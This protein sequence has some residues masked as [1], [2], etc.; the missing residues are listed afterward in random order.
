MPETPAWPASGVGEPATTGM[1]VKVEFQ[2]VGRRL[3]VPDGSSVYQAARQAGVELTS[4]CGGKGKCGLCTVQVRHGD[5]GPLT[6]E[7]EFL[8]TEAD[9]ATGH[10]LACRTRLHT[11]VLV[12][13]PRG[14]QVSGQRLQVDAQLLEIDPRP[15][16]ASFAFDL[17]APTLADHRSDL[18]RLT[19]AVVDAGGPAGVWARPR[20]VASL[21]RALRD[22]DGVGTAYLRGTELIGIA[23]PDAPALGLAVDLGTTKIAAQ[24]VDLATGEVLQST[25]AP[26]PQISYGEDLISRLDHAF[27]HPEEGRAMAEAVHRTLDDQ[28]GAMVAAAG[29]DRREVVDAIIVA[30]TA[31]EHLLLGYPV[32]Q[33]VKS[34]FVAA[35]SDWAELPATELGIR[36][37]RGAYVGIPPVVGGF[38]GADHVAMVLACDLVR[39]GRT[40]IGIDIGTNTE[41]SLYLPQTGRLYATSS[42]SGPAFE[43]AH[44]FDGMRAA[45]GAI[46]KVRIR[47]G[48]AEVITIDNV[49]AV[50]ICG[51]GIL[52]AVAQLHR[53]GLLNGRARLVEAPQITEG[54]AGKQ[55]TLV[56]AGH[57]GTGRPIVVTQGDVN[58]IQLAK[59]AINAAITTLLKATGTGAEQVAD[60]VIAGAFGSFLSV[61][62]VLAIGMFPN[63]PNAQIRQVGN[64]ALVGARWALVN[65]EARTAARDLVTRSDYLELTIQPGFSATFAR[66]MM[67][68]RA[69]MTR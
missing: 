5:A 48:R 8:L 44:I 56:D 21:P 24:L 25:G 13:V 2:P 53:A 67:L 23:G 60:V 59:G 42:P 27:H 4:A 11:D 41:I 20:T 47:D 10:R 37:A 12:S 54:P 18:T 31:M 40:A 26:N 36:M 55:F 3:E 62:S 39:R 14:S 35:A 38:V 30:N 50:G 63:L 29:A 66:G 64:A 58:E 49:P 57:S 69:A 6:P 46:E 52:D 1:S 16:I 22:Q 43:G 68:P 61:E 28:L 15:S 45:S 51:S 19:D 17:M 9:R 32:G 65:S 34:P 7:E 33:L